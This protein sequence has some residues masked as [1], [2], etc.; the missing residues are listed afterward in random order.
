MTNDG[1]EN[2]RHVTCT[3]H[4]ARSDK[5]LARVCPSKLSK[6]ELEDIYFSLL[7]NNT[8]LKKTINSQRDQIKVLT[9]K[10]HRMTV[11]KT[12]LGS[13]NKDCCATAKGILNEQKETIE[14]LKKAN[15]RL[16]DRIRFLNM[17]ICSA[18][19]F[20]KRSPTQSTSRHLATELQIEKSKVSELETQVKSA[21]IS[22]QVADVLEKHLITLTNRRSSITPSKAEQPT[23][24][25]ADLNDSPLIR[26][27][28]FN[29]ICF[30]HAASKPDLCQ[31][32]ARICTCQRLPHRDVSI[33]RTC[34]GTL[35]F[36]TTTSLKNKFRQCHCMR[37]SM[38]GAHFDGCPGDIGATTIGLM[39]KQGRTLKP[40]NTSTPDRVKTYNAERSAE[41]TRSTSPDNTEH[42]IS[43]LTDF[44][45]EDKSPRDY[46]SPGEE[47]ATS[48]FTDSYAGAT[49]TDY[50]SLSLGEVPMI[51]G[52]RRLPTR[53]RKPFEL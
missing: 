14:D 22:S 21:D 11:Q 33:F 8:Q 19:Q 12:P 23:L 44:P 10:V 37:D 2:I 34:S 4:A 38:S 16:S 20:L 43:S 1:K 29:N 30:V 41:V 13:Q 6:R 47:R 7:E 28:F 9:T 31:S 3:N 53:W 35:R 5:E 39:P 45:N 25:A 32:H 18:K 42:E 49:T 17:R 27:C 52:C 15:E 48:S 51:G 24:G 50:G 40:V 26:A 46:V 36:K